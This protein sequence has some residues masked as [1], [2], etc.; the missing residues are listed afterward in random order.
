MHSIEIYESR[1]ANLHWRVAAQ[2]LRSIYN[3][4]TKILVQTMLC[5]FLCMRRA[6][7][8]IFAHII[9]GTHQILHVSSELLVLPFKLFLGLQ[10]FFQ[11]SCQ[12]QGL[13]LFFSCLCLSTVSFLCKT[14][15]YIF[16]FCQ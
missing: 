15:R 9:F 4:E 13:G 14:G 6:H 1:Q 16:L 10:S 5:S 12:R 2:P 7:T 8:H 3:K 11:G